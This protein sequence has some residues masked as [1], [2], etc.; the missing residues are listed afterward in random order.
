MADRFQKHISVDGW[1]RSKNDTKTLV[2]MQI[3]CSVFHKVKTMRFQKRIS[4]PSGL[5]MD[6][7]L[8]RLCWFHSLP[9]QVN[10]LY[11]A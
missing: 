11:A 5:S 10:G 2:W 6:H 4:V 9:V 7:F 8:I 3:L 1:K